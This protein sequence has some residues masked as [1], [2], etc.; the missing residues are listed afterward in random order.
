MFLRCAVVAVILALALPPPATAITT[1]PP[2]YDWPA[3]A[4]ATVEK[5]LD[6]AYRYWAVRDIVPWPRSDVVIRL[7]HLTSP[8]IQAMALIGGNTIWFDD[9]YFLHAT[10]P[11][12]D[13]WMR[14]FVQRDVCAVTVHEVGHTAGLYDGDVRYPLM[15]QLPSRG[16]YDC[17]VAFPLPHTP[18]AAPPP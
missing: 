10:R 1:S 18:P 2:P 3:P 4:N 8:P 12:R 17:R 13:A 9:L 14:R 5:S 11:R 15:V 7:A 6:V 16:V